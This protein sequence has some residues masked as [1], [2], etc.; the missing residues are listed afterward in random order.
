MRARASSK[1]L[2][3]NATLQSYI[4]IS[5]E[6]FTFKLDI[7][8]FQTFFP[9]SL[10]GSSPTR[11]RSLFL[12][13]HGGR[14]G[15][16]PANEDAFFPAVPVDVCELDAVK[17]WPIEQRTLP[18]FFDIYAERGSNLQFAHDKDLIR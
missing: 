7:F 16:D 3:C 18:A 12:A 4:F 10:P 1:F 2:P 13:R 15:E 14:L 17:S 6:Q 5:Y 8:D 9:N 11:L